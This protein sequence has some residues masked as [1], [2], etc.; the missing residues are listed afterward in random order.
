MIK[1]IGV[2]TA[3]LVAV[4]AHAGAKYQE[5]VET[6][7][8]PIEMATTVYSFSRYRPTQNGMEVCFAEH[9]ALR[10]GCSSWTPMLAAVPKGRTFVGWRIGHTDYGHRVLDIYFK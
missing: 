6:G 8:I 5:V 9:Y 4:A 7:I 3:S 1:L 2:V 10:G